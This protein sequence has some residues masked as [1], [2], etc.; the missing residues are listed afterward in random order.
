MEIKFELP[1]NFFKE[2]TTARIA[3]SG[4][5]VVDRRAIGDQL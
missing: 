2:I 4:S 3:A 5:A 1:A